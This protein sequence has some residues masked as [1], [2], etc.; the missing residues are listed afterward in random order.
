MIMA[1]E[2]YDVYVFDGVPF[3]SVK[4]LHTIQTFVNKVA[5]NKD[6]S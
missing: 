4:I 5:F 6:G 1:G 3:K 2:D